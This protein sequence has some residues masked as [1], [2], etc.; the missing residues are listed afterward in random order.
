[1]KNAIIIHGMPSKEEFESSKISPANSHFIP[2]IK[3]KLIQGGIDAISLDM[4][5]PYNPV[6]ESWKEVFEKSDINEETILVGHSCG[7]GFLVRWL[8][9]N[10]VKVGKVVLVA[11]WLDPEK[12]LNTGMF[13]FEIDPAFPNRSTKVIVMYSTDDEE[14]ILDTIKILKEKTNG[15][16]FHEFQDKGHFCIEDLESEEFPELL[17][18]ILE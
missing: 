11:P 18:L 10:K 3:N 4:P 12:Y 7:G 9:E 5:V 2:W 8:S 17:N 6:Y 1:M 15:I 16:D 13:D 14:Y